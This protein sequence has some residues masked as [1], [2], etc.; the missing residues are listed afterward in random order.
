MP[1]RRWNRVIGPL[2]AGALAVGVIAAVGL[3]RQTTRQ[4]ASVLDVGRQGP[5]PLAG[6]A[7]AAP[8]QATPEPGKLYV[9]RVYVNDP[10]QQARLLS[11]GWDVLEARGPDYLL[12]TADSETLAGLGNAGFK[13]SLDSELPPIAPGA[14]DTYY[15]GYRTVAEHIAHLQAVSNTYPAL[16]SVITYGL[17]WKRTQNAAD[18]TELGAVGGVLG[19]L[20]R[21]AVGDDAGQGGISVRHRLQMGNVLGN[22]AVS[23]IVGVGGAGRDWRKLAVQRP[24]EARISQAGEGLAVGGDQQIVWTARFEHVP[25]AA[26]QAG[27]LHGVVHI[28]PGH[29]ELPWLGGGL[30]GRGI[31]LARQRGRSLPAHVQ[32][33]RRLPSRLA[34][35]P[36]SGDDADSKRSCEEGSYHAIPAAVGHQSDS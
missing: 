17:S 2:L 27:L 21:Q 5:T 31:G 13:W 33:G 36:D 15:G 30:A 19:P 24:L 26:E 34:R 22:G 32:H 7:D 12:V 23:A 14:A 29:I 20:P 16:T 3:A 18:G 6:K 1:N 11:G 35:Q 10:M 4:P 9:A 25:S 8:S 28:D